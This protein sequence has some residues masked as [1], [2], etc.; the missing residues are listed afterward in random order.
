MK[1]FVSLVFTLVLALGSAAQSPSKV[2]KDAEKAL[3]GAK[4]IRAVAS[5]VKTGTI[6][7][8]S[9]GATGRYLLQTSQPNLFNESYDLG[10]FEFESG[11]NGRSAWE[12]NSRDGL[13]TL[14]GKASNDAQAAAAFRNSLWF[15]A[16]KQKARLTS[17]GQATVNGGPA[18]VVVL[19]TQKGTVIK[20]YFDAGNGLLVREEVPVGEAVAATDYSGHRLVNGVMMPFAMHVEQ[21]GEAF[22]VTIEDVKVNTQVARADFDF[23]QVSG[24]PLPDIPM[25]LQELQTNEDRVESILDN[26]SFK[27]TTVTRELGKDGVLREKESETLELSFYRGFRITRFVEKNGR[28]L[29][30]K[31]Q[32]EADKD[33]EKQVA[34]IEK[35]IAKNESRS[36]KLDSTGK[37]SEDSRRISIAEVLRAS[38]LI[39]PRRE[40]F[41]GR[42]VVVFDFEPNP[43]FDLKNARSVL[44]FF[45]KTAGVMWVDAEDKQVARLEAVLVDSISMGGGLLAKFK[46][47]ATFMLEK[48]RVGNEIWLPSQVDINFSAR[49]LL[50]KGID[51]N[52]VQRFY[53]HRKFATEVTDAKVDEVKK[54]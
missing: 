14:T 28:P 31:E 2:L 44:R 4:A 20:L 15:D 7:R 12:R 35:R 22:D 34:E 37:P 1:F 48:E 49:V 54:P 8:K 53:D 10:G 13:R 26:Y 9:D 23:P 52:Q 29:T 33:A 43:Q 42:D 27:Q 32:A 17:G 18:N 51:L 19:T 30:A 21:G 39:N 36:G 45:G 41:R 46:K 24:Q 3:G 6:Q 25:L 16:R 50:F 40:R 38:R 47:G 5:V 11:Y